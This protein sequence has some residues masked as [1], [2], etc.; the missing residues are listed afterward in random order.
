MV[1]GLSCILGNVNVVS[2]SGCNA[3]ARVSVVFVVAME[4]AEVLCKQH[5]LILILLPHE[6]SKTSDDQRH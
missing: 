1:H 5:R 2:K 6:F 4:K 3:M